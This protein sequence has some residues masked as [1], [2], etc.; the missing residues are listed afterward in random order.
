MNSI[1]MQRAVRRSD[2]GGLSA[3]SLE[4]VHLYVLNGCVHVLLRLCWTTICGQI[5][6]MYMYAETYIMHVIL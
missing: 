2:H 1:S 6:L 5:D 3:F 4:V